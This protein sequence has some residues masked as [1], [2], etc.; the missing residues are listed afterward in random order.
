MQG[1]GLEQFIADPLPR[2]FRGQQT[3]MIMNRLLGGFRQP[4]GQQRPKPAPPDHAHRIF[5]DPGGGIACK[6]ND[7]PFQV[8][9]AAMR[10]LQ[11]VVQRI[12]CHGIDREIPHGQ[13]IFRKPPGCGAAGDHFDIIDQTH[14]KG[15]AHHA[16]RPA[17]KQGFQD[18]DGSM[19]Q[20]I[21]ILRRPFLTHV[22]HGPAHH[23]CS[24]AVIPQQMQQIH[25][26]FW[27]H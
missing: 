25:Y 20:N 9:P 22:P 3:G 19:G 12:I 6:A 15:I 5:L 27:D 7:A 2:D 24:N 13:I 16:D 4:C 11:P 26:R 17:F 21:H 23:K 14:R 8:S 1:H 18:I 10:V